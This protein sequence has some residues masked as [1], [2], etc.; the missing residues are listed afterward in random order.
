M[1]NNVPLVAV[2][3]VYDVC[4]VGISAVLLSLSVIHAYKYTT[5]EAIKFSGGFVIDTIELTKW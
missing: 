4:V 1:H 3:I 2:E 5:T